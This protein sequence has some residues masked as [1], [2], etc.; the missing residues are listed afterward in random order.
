MAIFK[1]DPFGGS[2][3]Y[4]KFLE[5]EKV[6]TPAG[7][8]FYVVPGHPAYVYD[9]V[10]SNASGRKVFRANPSAAISKQEQ[11]ERD[12]KKA[13][14]QQNFNQ[15]PA[16]QLVPV[17]AGTAGTVGAAYVINNI[18][19][20]TPKLVQ[21]LGNG[22]GRM[23]DGTIKPIAQAINPVANTTGQ[24]AANAPA[25]AAA[26]PQAS[27]AAQGFTG[28]A[29]A[30]GAAPTAVGTAANG[31]TIMSD[32]SVVTNTL[33]EGASVTPAGEVV[34]AQ[35]SPIGDVIQGA[36][37][38][39]Q[40]Y[41]GVKNFKNDKIGGSLDIASGG[42]NVA[43]AVG[44]EAAAPFAGPLM[45]AKG[46]YD[47]IKA[48]N[49]NGE[50]LRSGLTQLGAGIG[51]MIMPGLGTG[52]GAAA[53]NV[54]GY[55]LQG[56]GIKNDLAL[57]AVSPM[58]L[59]LKKFGVIDSLMHKTTRQS[60][61]EN[62]QN[63]LESNKEN[64]AYQDYVK[65]QREQFYAPPPDPSK[66]FYGGKYGSFD[67]YKKAGLVASDLTGVYGNIKTYGPEWAGLTEEQRRAITQKNI[68]SGLYTSKKGEVEITDEAKALQN[69]IDVMRGFGVAPATTPAAPG[70]ATKAAQPANPVLAVAAAQGSKV[71]PI[72]VPARSTT[73]SPGIG[74]NGMPIA[75]RR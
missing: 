60:S 47:S 14:D 55:G 28:T 34:N 4:T 2:V 16:G 20:E 43:Q 61:I 44:V 11:A 17:V 22:F 32:G 12:Q 48:F 7:Q 71:P 21:D 13:Q 62:T 59:P 45:A 18:G 38:L 40:I 25:A 10:A 58:L 23:S 69:K 54:V 26:S 64:K 46:T 65:A 39:Y 35:G 68:E 31:G 52:V 1:N 51:T 67:E 8:V 9:P 5:W 74:I 57:M 37:G 73:R 19:K 70:A 66:P 29:P 3:D 56:N 50:G 63:L 49:R 15:S 27:A 6:T 33:P 53:G 24:V 36:A 41:S 42:A 72:V 75:V 30:A